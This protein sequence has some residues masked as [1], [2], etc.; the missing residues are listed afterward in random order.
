[1]LFHFFFFDEL[2]NE[3]NFESWKSSEFDLIRKNFAKTPKI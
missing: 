2:P 1:M 3:S